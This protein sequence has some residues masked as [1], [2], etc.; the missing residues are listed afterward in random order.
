MPK[1]A[2]TVQQ[3]ISEVEACIVWDPYLSQSYLIIVRDCLRA[4]LW[5]PAIVYCGV[6]LEAHLLDKLDSSAEMTTDDLLRAAFKGKMISS[7]QHTEIE[8][9]LSLRDG[10]AHPL[11]FLY[12]KTRRNIASVQRRYK[13]EMATPQWLLEI[14]STAKRVRKMVQMYS[15]NLA[16]A[17]TDSTVSLITQIQ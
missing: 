3:V 12:K 7:P 15:Q 1:P 13:V 14:D 5:G 8:Q 10:H 17:V 16:L 9:I 11:T 6:A 2:L 4:G